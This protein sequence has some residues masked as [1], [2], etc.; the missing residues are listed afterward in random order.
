M[1]ET[2]DTLE[3]LTLVNQTNGESKDYLLADTLARQQIAAQIS[4]NTDQ[5]NDYASEVVDARVGNDGA[6]HASLGV[7]IRKQKEDTNNKIKAL[8]T[9]TDYCSDI[10]KV[11][12][13][14]ITNATINSNGVIKET[15]GKDVICF[16]VVQ[17]KTI[18]SVEGTYEIYAFYTDKP[19]YESSSYNSSRMITNEIADLEIPSNC[20]WIAIRVP[21]GMRVKI[22]PF[23]FVI[24]EKIELYDK[25]G[26]TFVGTNSL[27]TL[28][29]GSNN[30]AIGANAMSDSDNISD[31]IALGANAQCTQS[32]QM[33]LGGSNIAEVVLCGDKKIIFNED[34]TV[35]WESIAEEID[36]EEQED[37][38]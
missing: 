28:E 30:T 18:E 29:S 6:T 20:N 25:N 34:G 3:L 16:Q 35:T 11:G 32:N 4:A 24:G 5:N 37:N 21:S 23:S 31:S 9:E 22:K 13:K 38:S 7:A 26:N 36:T 8:K 14:V 33:V 15:A 2:L 27:S 19:D 17:N 1:A 12:Y 10:I